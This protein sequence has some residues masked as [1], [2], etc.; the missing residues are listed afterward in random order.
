MQNIKEALDNPAEFDEFKKK[1][2]KMNRNFDNK[3]YGKYF[4]INGQIIPDLKDEY[5]KLLKSEGS[6]MNENNEQ[7]RK[8]TIENTIDSTLKEDLENLEITDTTTVVNQPTGV[9]KEESRE[10][11]DRYEE[12]NK[13]PEDAPLFGA[14]DQPVPDDVV[15]PKL[16]LE[17]D[18]FNQS[19]AEGLSEDLIYGKSSLD[20][21]LDV[22]KK[23]YRGLD[24]DMVIDS[25]FWGLPDDLA[26]EAAVAIGEIVEDALDESLNEGKSITEGQDLDDI[27]ALFAGFIDES[28]IDQIFK[29]GK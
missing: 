8:N 17:E 7:L 4:D 3:K 10:F 16:T 14:K 6:P 21:Y 22:I 15:E 26:Y 13:V 5:F 19:S 24:S 29:A 18:L 12:A 20:D 25:I 28:D 27:K 11:E 2:P 23:Y 1:N 9:A